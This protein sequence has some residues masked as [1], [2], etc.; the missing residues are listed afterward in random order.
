[1]SDFKVV[2]LLGAP[3]E[4]NFP[5]NINYTGAYSNVTAYATGDA[6]SY[7][8]SSYVAL[9]ATT[10]NI[11]TNTSFW[12]LLAEKGDTGAT[13]PAG[14]TGTSTFTALTDVPNSYAGQSLKTVRVNAGATGLE[15]TTAVDTDEKVKV[16]SNDTTAK[17]LEDA[18]TVSHGT[19]AST[20]LAKTT[21]NDGGD[22]D[23]QIQFD[24]SKVDL[25]LANNTTSDFASK[26]YA[27]A[28]VT[29]NTAIV[30]ATK[31]K[32]TYDAKGLITS[33]ADAT[34][35]DIAEGTN[36]YFTDERAQ[37]AVGGILTNTTTIDLAYNDGLNTISA[38]VVDGSI[39]NVKVA[40]GIDAAK[41][42]S[43][44]VSNTEF[45]YLNG[46]TSAIQTQINGKYSN[47]TGLASQYIKG[48]GTFA[49]FPTNTGGGGGGAVYYFNGGTSQGTISGNPYYELSLA[50]NTGTTATF[51][52]TG[53]GTLASFITD[54]GSPNVLAVPAGIWIFET[55]LTDSSSGGTLPEIY[56]EVLKYDGTTFTTIAT[57]PIQQIT[58]GTVKELYTFAA[59]IPSGVTLAASDRIAINLKTSN[60]TGR[61]VTIYTE[62]G[63]ISAVQTTFT[64]GIASING[65]TSS[66]QYFGVGTTGTD[67]GIS[68]T[69]DTH[70]FNIPSASATNRGALTSSDWTTFNN[71][72][73]VANKSTNNA[74]GTSDILYPTQKAVK[75]YTDNI[76]S[77]KVSYTDMQKTALAYVSPS[78]SNTT[79]DGSFARP[80]LTI[81]YTI[82]NTSDGATIFL[83]P[84]LYTEATVII[85]PGTGSR[86]FRGFS[87]NATEL[88]NGISHTAN[89][90][91]INFSFDSININSA[92]LD[93]TAATNGFIY[94]T[95]CWF[96]VTRV[97]NNPNIVF[98]STESNVNSATLSG[99]NNV[100]NEALVLGAIV[101]N[102]GFN[103]FENCKFVTTLQAQGATTVRMLDCESFGIASFVNG[104]IVSTNTP[105]WE[106][107]LSTEY[108]GGFTGSV[109]KTILA[110]IS[111]ALGF[112]P[113]NVANKATD[114]TSPNNT[115]YPTTQAVATE[116]L[117]K[118]GNT[119]ESVSKNLR[120]YN[121][122][123]NYSS[124]V[125]TTIVYTIPSVGTITKTLNYSSGVLTS[126]VLSG[127]TPASI[128][129]TKTLTY[130]LGV[131]T[132]VAYS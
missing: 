68:S 108:L 7:L 70:T 31:T 122:T 105:V 36:L 101:C 124:G 1:M 2:K 117:L 34:T 60:A 89:A 125:L 18:I 121:Y 10:G 3:V 107:D 129:L 79:G 4:I 59:S 91:N 20:V 69:G 23:V 16:S 19:N 77:N 78:G 84:G 39:T 56:A 45:E 76:A 110:N 102:G 37:D 43:G 51:N 67:F 57:G 28:K 130:T 22:E 33:G 90:S 53:N 47:P 41:I 93:E 9:G 55:Y 8:G 127:S 126:V 24:V 119:F 29:A 131:L 112:T 35:S 95:K 87:A 14:P 132:S 120:Q 58:Q 96:S 118:I 116:S 109:T 113:E 42:A 73:D 72:E 88:Q 48:D 75:E 13:G 66:T 128:Q 21:L 40:S 26:S 32:I 52:I 46:V 98:T 97:D 123:L 15:F 61:T 50:A 27:D 100:F 115:K 65:L 17:Y 81:A 94:F 11:P 80:Y 30:G 114:L 104:T 64:T 44:V 62:N 5:G 103:V 38:N 111:T 12:Q 86:A 49:A 54:V 83:L 99:S 6:V 85:P 63:N 82:S 71:K 25:S 74:L 106:V 92:T